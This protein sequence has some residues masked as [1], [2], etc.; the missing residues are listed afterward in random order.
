MLRKMKATTI[1]SIF[2]IFLFSSCDTPLIGLGGKVD[3]SVPQIRSLSVANGDYLKGEVTITGTMDDDIG[4]SS[5]ALS[6]MQNGLVAT[7][8]TNITV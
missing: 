7:S 3:L 5:V 4:V 6:L 1:C 8:L 2:I